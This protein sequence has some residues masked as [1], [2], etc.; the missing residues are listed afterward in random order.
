MGKREEILKMIENSH[1]M[2][3]NIFILIQKELING[4]SLF[5]S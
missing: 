1:V 4:Y 5:Q 2:M 3:T